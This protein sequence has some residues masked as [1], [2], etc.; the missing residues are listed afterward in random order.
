MVTSHQKSAISLLTGLMVIFGLL[1]PSSALAE[2]PVINIWYGHH[3]IFGQPGMPQTWVN[4][5]G[6]VSPA[7]NLVSVTYSLNNGPARSLTIGSDRRRLTEAGD[8]NIDLFHAELLA[9]LNELIITATN[10]DNQQTTETMTIEYLPGQVWPLPSTVDW[11]ST[12]NIQD[13]AQVVDGLWQLEAEGARPVILGYDRL[14]T[15]GDMTWKNYEV[16][17][18]ITIHDAEP[19]YEAPSNGAWVGLVMRWRGH[20][21]WDDSQPAYG[22]WPL[23]A[24]T[25]LHFYPPL[26]QQISLRGNKFL[27]LEEDTTGRQ[28]EFNVTYNFKLRGETI[29]GYSTLYSLKIWEAS[30]PEPAGWDFK[31]QQRLWD[32]IY[33]SV[34]LVAHHVDAT[35]GPV[36]VMPVARSAWEW[37]A[38]LGSYAAQL[39]VVLVCLGAI[40]FSWLYRQQYPQVTR[41]TLLA[42]ILL[43]LEAVGG[44][45]LDIQLPLWLHQQN[46]S[47]HEIGLALVTSEILQS[48]MVALAIGLLMLAVFRWRNKETI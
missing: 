3:Q 26:E 13:V 30:Q 9:G 40:I 29:P 48:V 17:V 31:G 35:F 1:T 7:D 20:R 19:V 43:A 36:T 12:D 27:P 24:A 8:F 15:F 25:P 6:N 44:T 5:L 38:L 33:G 28:L 47:T 46:W 39:P 23:G 22:W 4:I 10:Q 21:I 41:L 37:F 2:A 14:I 18:P 11:Q 45:F 34:L 42:T 16:T 32:P